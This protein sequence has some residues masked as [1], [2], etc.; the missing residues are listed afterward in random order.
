MRTYYVFGD[1]GYESECE[2]YSTNNLQEA[3]DFA[4][5]YTRWG[6]FGGYNIIEVAWF[7][8][9]GEYMTEER[10]MAED[11]DEFFDYGD[12]EPEWEYFSD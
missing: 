10:I 7:N 4:R 11:M 2:L 5:N 6:D 9:D 12:E 3:K 8:E 1:Y